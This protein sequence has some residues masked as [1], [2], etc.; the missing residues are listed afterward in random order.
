M[1]SLFQY[2][3]YKKIIV[4]IAELFNILSGIAF[5]ISGISASVLNDKYAYLVICL[6]AIVNVLLA[7]FLYKYYKI[8]DECA[9]EAELSII[10][11]KTDVEQ[12]YRE[13]QAELLKLQKRNEEQLEKLRNPFNVG[14]NVKSKFNI[15]SKEKGETIPSGTIGKVV[16][17]TNDGFLKVKFT[18]DGKKVIVSEKIDIFKKI[19]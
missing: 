1:K 3:K 15:Y 17:A 7:I 16:E 19:Y 11:L 10:K 18:I 2:F 9:K 6:G 5:I 12:Q 8:V 14:D 13:E 4:R